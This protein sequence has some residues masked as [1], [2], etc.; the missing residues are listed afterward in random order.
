MLRDGATRSLGHRGRIG[1]PRRLGGR[2][3]GGAV[4]PCVLG[5]LVPPTRADWLL[6]T[7][8]AV[9]VLLAA[10]L[11]GTLDSAEDAVLVA[12]LVLAGAVA[13]LTVADLRRPEPEEAAGHGPR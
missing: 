1:G 7:T 3:G 5:A 12:G 8:H 11:A 4:E 13:L 10:R 9:V 6:V 2:T